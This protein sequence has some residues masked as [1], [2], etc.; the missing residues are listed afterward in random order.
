MVWGMF[1]LY[2]QE[3]GVYLASSAALCFYP[4]ILICTGLYLEAFCDQV[5]DIF[6]KIDDCTQSRR[7]QSEVDALLRD[8]IQLQMDSSM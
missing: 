1:L 5:I 4:T 8:A 3:V 7:L 2:I 6:G